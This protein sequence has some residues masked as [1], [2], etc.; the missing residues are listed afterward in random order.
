[1]HLGETLLETGDEVEEILKGQ[2]RMQSTDDVE[3]GHRFAIAGS[4][5]R[6]SLFERHRIGSRRILFPP[7]GTEAAGC[8]ADIGRV[9]MPIDVEVGDVAVESL[10][11]VVGQPTYGQNVTRPIEGEAIREVQPLARKNFAGDRPE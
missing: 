5:C 11:H 10:P 1:M 6:P 8:H 4:R 9:D 7:E 2:V 3:L